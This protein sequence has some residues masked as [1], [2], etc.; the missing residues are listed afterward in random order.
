[1]RFLEK[2]RRAKV[3]KKLPALPSKAALVH[4]LLKQNIIALLESIPRTTNLKYLCVGKDTFTNIQKALD[5][6][7][8]WVR[9]CDRDIRIRWRRSSAPDENMLY[10]EQESFVASRALSA[11]LVGLIG[12]EMSLQK[13]YDAN[14]VSEETIK[15]GEFIQSIVCESEQDKRANYIRAELSLREKTLTMFF[16]HEGD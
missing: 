5:K 11:R 4:E 10:T 6:K 16:G 1:M 7:K 8:L 14:R 9:V 12:G 13:A 2:V 3:A 15:K